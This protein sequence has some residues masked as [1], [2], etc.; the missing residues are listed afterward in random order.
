MKIE[1][2]YILITP[3]GRYVCLRVSASHA[4]NPTYRKDFVDDVNDAQIFTESMDRIS[5]KSKIDLSKYI[6][7]SA[8]AHRTVTLLPQ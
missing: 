1:S 8:K 7:I 4:I 5:K 3:I 6:P 2:G